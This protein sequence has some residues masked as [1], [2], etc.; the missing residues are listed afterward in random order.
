VGPID[1]ILS[2]I[3]HYGYLVVLFGVMLES[4]G[5][6]LPGETILLAAGVMVQR[7]HLHLGDAI[8]FGILG[9]V[10]GDQIGYWVGREGGRPFILRWGRYVFITPERLGRAEAF[11]ARHGGKAVFFARFFSGLRVFGAL[12]AGM[13]RMRWG[14]FFLYNALGGATWATA[15]VLVGYFLGSSLSL[16]ERWMGRATI[17]LVGVLIIA[18]I[19]YLTYRWVSAHPE[20]LRRAAQRLGGARLRAFLRSPAGLWLR[21]RFSPREVYGLALTTGLVLT[22]LLSWAFG[23]IAQD[24]V[25]RDPLVRTEVA[26]LR[27]F[28]SY[29]DPQLT[30]AVI[31]FE[32]LFSPVVL[33]LAA[34][35]A[36]IVLAALARRRKDFE[37]GF[38]GAVLVATALGTG[39]LAQSSKILFHRPRPPAS[40][41]LVHPSGYGFPSFHAMAV[42]AVG[43]VVWYLFSIR[44]PESRGGSWQA[45]ARVGLAAIS[46]ALV[47]GL[48]RVY[49]GASYPSDVLAGWALGGVWA[50]VCLTAAELFRRLRASSEPLPEAG[51]QYAQFSLVGASNALVDLGTINLL[52]LIE[53]T[54]S[55]KTLV[56][57]NLVALV[58]A[59]ANSYLWNTLWTFRHHARHDAKQVGMFATQA[60][61]GIGV[62][63]LV[64]WLVARGLVA[65]SDLSPLEVGNIAKL[66]SMLVGSTTSF[67]LLRFVVFRS[68]ERGDRPP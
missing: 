7:G 16:V 31:V 40:L 48:G 22:G 21:R 20:R 52:L 38:S 54:R 23:G 61:V 33:L 43:A 4:M 41:Q 32:T 45:K 8:V 39:A 63:S 51:I 1:H 25:A 2:L 67:L 12:V 58:L 62:G 50:S 59:N 68:K 60:V 56:L 17:L 5:V 3:A 10:V 24:L 36:G 55:P 42:V 46:V 15:V 14:T 64:L 26:I 6:P 11:F 65:Y 28:H 9:A 66:S 18:T 19:L 29:S 57:Y 35:L 44:P 53:P 30:F 37:A 13:S 34:T 27:F 49:E 47:V